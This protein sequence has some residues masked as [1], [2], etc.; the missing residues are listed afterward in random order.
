MLLVSLPGSVLIHT[1]DAIWEERKLITGE[2]Y[3]THCTDIEDKQIITSQNTRDNW[4]SNLIGIH[5]PNTVLIDKCDVQYV[6]LQVIIN[7]GLS[8]VSHMNYNS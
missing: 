4:H 3:E 1:P 2:N 8:A 7:T 5:R 6:Q